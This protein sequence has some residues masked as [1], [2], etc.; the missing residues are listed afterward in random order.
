MTPGALSSSLSLS[1]TSIAVFT[2]IG[3]IS[4]IV[5]WSFYSVTLIRFV[6]E[7]S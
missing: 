6:T 4:E 5:K 3:N 7:Y 1:V 2:V